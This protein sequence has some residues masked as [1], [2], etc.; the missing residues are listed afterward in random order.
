[1]CGLRYSLPGSV[2]SCDM[3]DETLALAIMKLSGRFCLFERQRA[4]M[5]ADRFGS[6]A[7]VQSNWRHPAYSVEKLIFREPQILSVN[8]FVA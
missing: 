3:R 2:G 4:A 6:R 7:T 1:M 8:R 5:A